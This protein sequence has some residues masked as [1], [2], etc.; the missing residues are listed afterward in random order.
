MKHF[1]N[2]AAMVLIFVFLILSIGLNV[3]QYLNAEAKENR[4]DSLISAGT[5]QK[6]V[7]TYQ[8]DSITHNVYNETIINNNRSEKELAVGKT[9]ADSLQKALKVSI[10]KI[11]QVTKY[12]AVLEARL[13]L[14]E[15][16]NPAP[17][18][19]ETPKRVL[20]HKDKTITLNYYPETDSADLKVDVGLNDTR[21]SKR[22]WLL[23][24]QQNYIDI[25]PDDK[26][27]TIKG[28]KSY[29]IKERPQ[30]RFGIGISAGY[31]VGQ[32]GNTLKTIPYAGIGINYNLFEF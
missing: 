22:K 23:G 32:D 29:T 17:M 15:S 3:K 1:A 20:T 8:R 28:L 21:Y 26:R 9:Y 25:F 10:N 6:P 7:E 19:G 16:P 14:K 11:D 2:T 24:N 4:L 13:A 31:G 30:K 5:K 12:N 18:P 27:V